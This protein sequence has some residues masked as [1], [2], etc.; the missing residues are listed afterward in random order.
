M[1]Q[2]RQQRGVEEEQK[3]KYWHESAW[4]L[5]GTWAEPFPTHP[6]IQPVP[7]PPFPSHPGPCTAAQLGAHIPAAFTR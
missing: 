2:K 7:I 1:G 3:S 5:P 4:E 6:C